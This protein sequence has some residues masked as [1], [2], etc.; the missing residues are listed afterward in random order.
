[1]I[2]SFTIL[3][4]VILPVDALLT[5]PRIESVKDDLSKGCGLLLTEL[6]RIELGG[7]KKGSLRGFFRTVKVSLNDLLRH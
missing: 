1:M 2:D 3:I 6:L 7:S 4:F 5:D